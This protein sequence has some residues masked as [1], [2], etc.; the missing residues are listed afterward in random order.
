MPVENAG[1]A[2]V[3]ICFKSGSKVV[4]LANV[5]LIFRKTHRL[6]MLKVLK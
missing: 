1:A 2:F 6:A 3:K 4:V 5:E